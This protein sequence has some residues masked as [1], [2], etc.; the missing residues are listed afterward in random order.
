MQS[1]LWQPKPSYRVSFIVENKQPHQH[2][3]QQQLQPIT[4]ASATQNHF[5]KRLSPLNAGSAGATMRGTK[6]HPF[7][8]QK[9][10]V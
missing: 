5:A 2:Y 3:S 6:G 7:M 10:M 8:Q 4:N 9:Q 1:Q